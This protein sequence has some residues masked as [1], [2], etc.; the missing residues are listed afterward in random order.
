[1][2]LNSTTVAQ[3]FDLHGKVAIVTGAGSGIGRATACRLAEA[4]ASVVVADIDWNSSNRL[5]GQLRTE[6]AEALAILA[7]ARSANDAEDAVRMAV[8][9]FGRVDI[10]VNNAGIYPPSPALDIDATLWGET[11]DVNLKGMLFYCQMAVREMVS[12][13]HGGKIVNIASI[14]GLHPTPGM[15]HYAASKGGVIML[16][17]GLALEFAPHGI[18]VN[19]VAPGGIA[20]PGTQDLVE[21]IHSS[22]KAMK[23][24]KEHVPFGRMGEADDVARVVLFLASAAADYITGSLIPVEGGALLA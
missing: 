9:S 22:D 24:F 8:A 11:L 17:K 13:G 21:E 18:N 15:A 6:G 1:M 3:L 23:R 5:V 4:G 12:E 16:T 10:L 14:V 2:P 20:T 19:A 7:D